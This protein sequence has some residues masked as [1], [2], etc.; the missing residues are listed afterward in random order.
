M[1]GGNN[2]FGNFSQLHSLQWESA[3]GFDRIDASGGSH[4]IHHAAQASLGQC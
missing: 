2:A 1:L 4:N 3:A